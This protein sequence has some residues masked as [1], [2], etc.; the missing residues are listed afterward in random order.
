MKTFN[1]ELYPAGKM[2]YGNETDYLSVDLEDPK[3]APVKAH[4]LSAERI[5]DVIVRD[6]KGMQVGEVK[7]GWFAQDI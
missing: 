4:Q 3:E 5:V 6:A 7:Y 2:S 1:F